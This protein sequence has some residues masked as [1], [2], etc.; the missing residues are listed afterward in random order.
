MTDGSPNMI[1]SVDIREEVSKSNTSLY[2]KST[3][4]A[5]LVL[6]EQFKIHYSIHMSSKVG[7]NMM[8]KTSVSWV[9]TN[10]K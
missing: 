10:N 6:R 5:A 3:H 7:Y 1:G 4:T 2:R 9:I 8:S